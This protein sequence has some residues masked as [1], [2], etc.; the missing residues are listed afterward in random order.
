MKAATDRR[1]PKNHPR[2]D[3]L[4]AHYKLEDGIAKKLTTAH[5]LIAQGRGEVFDY[6]LGERTRPFAKRACRAAAAMLLLAEKPILS[7]NGNTG[8]LVPE[9]LVSLAKRSGA[10]LEVNVFHERPGRRKAIA[11]HLYAHGATQVHGERPSGNID[12]LL[13]ARGKV[14]RKG[15]LL[16]DVVVVSLEDGDRTEILR[17]H[18]KK[19]IAID[20]NPF[21]RTVR[22]ANISII[23]NVMRALPCLEAQVKELRKKD[24][25]ALRRIIRAYDNKVVIRQAQK[26]ERGGKMA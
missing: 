11:K 15:M 6:L 14:D 3:V 17:Q 8:T 5:A 26:A 21:C 20:L 22:K 18:G 9:K 13:S 19:I 16:A 4:M 10:E 7:V 1:V 2:Y 25:A 24:E 23:D 12:G